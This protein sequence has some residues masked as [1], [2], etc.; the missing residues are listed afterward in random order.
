[1]S[2]LAQE[3]ARVADMDDDRD[4]GDYDPTEVLV[5]VHDT[6]HESFQVPK[7]APPAPKTECGMQQ[8]EAI[9]QMAKQTCIAKVISDRS[10][11]FKALSC[12][13]DSD[14]AFKRLVSRS[15]GL[16]VDVVSKLDRDLTEAE[17]VAI[18]AAV[19]R[20]SEKAAALAFL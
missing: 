13:K 19:K 2:Y 14:E 20:L 16:P 10:N 1:M 12:W 5:R 8:L 7:L 15:A 9:K 18:R 6:W 11:Q 17:K 4:H 3:A